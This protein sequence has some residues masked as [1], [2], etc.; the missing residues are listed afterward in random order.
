MSL[1]LFRN[2]NI[3]RRPTRVE[4]EAIAYPQRVKKILG[5]S[6]PRHLDMVGNLELLNGAG[7]GFCGARR[8]SEKGLETARDCSEQAAINGVLVVSG[9]AAGV[10]FEAHYTCL[11][12][13]G[14]TIFVLPE[15]INHFR[16]KRALKPV[17]DWN[18]VLV[19]SQFQP[20]EP[21]KE[22]RRQSQLS[23]HDHC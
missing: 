10:D 23:H 19:I 20:D 8:S 17:W 9:N 5:N 16:I 7:L 18:R 2:C 15:G 13:G 22:D 6:A 1:E 11:N 21:W 14:S 4:L 3:D 12:A